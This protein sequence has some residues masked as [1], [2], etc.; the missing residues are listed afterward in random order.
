MK[1]GEI[2]TSKTGKTKYVVVAFAPYGDNDVQAIVYG[3]KDFHIALRERSA[4]RIKRQLFKRK[5]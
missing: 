1:R 5:K 4:L 2:V 3:R